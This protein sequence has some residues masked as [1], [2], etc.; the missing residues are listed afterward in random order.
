[1]TQ[2]SP[3]ISVIIPARNEER[4]LPSCLRGIAVA[5]AQAALRVEII[6]VAN[7]CTDGTERIAQEAGCVVV[8]EDAKNLAKIRNAG[9]RAASADWI[10]TIDADSVMSSNSL[11]EIA[12]R[13]ADDRIIGGGTLILPERYSL[14]ILLTGLALSPFVF[15]AGLAAGMFWFRRKDFEAIRGF[16]ESYVSVEDIDFARRL[17]REGRRTGRR[18]MM[19]WKARIVTSCRKFDTFGDW[20]FLTNPMRIWGLLRGRNQELAD[21]VW[22]DFER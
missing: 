15:V 21:K 17:K 6:V 8:I 20:Y 1:M 22:Y 5:A 11:A 13:L 7:R 2:S 10:I 19:L 9:V 14:G 3:T 12:K 4:T 18:F 16:D